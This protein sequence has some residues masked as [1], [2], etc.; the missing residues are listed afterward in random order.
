MIKWLRDHW[1]VP[2]LTLFA[3]LAWIARLGLRPNEIARRQLAKIDRQ[4][5][6]ALEAIE[7]GKAAANEQ[8]DRE[9][10]ATLAALDEA[11]REKANYLR[12]D[13]ASRV[14]FLNAM[15]ERKGTNE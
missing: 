8:A 11:Q 1:Y 5:R 6:T 12:S 4:E 14:R 7:R 13:P 2:L 9:Y 15:S 3:A 10:A